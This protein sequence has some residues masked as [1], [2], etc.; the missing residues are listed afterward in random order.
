MAGWI[1][2]VSREEGST[3]AEVSRAEGSTTAEVSS[4]EGTTAEG[5]TPEVSRAEGTTAEASPAQSSPAQSSPA[6]S[7]PAQSIPAGAKPHPAHA[8][9]T[10]FDGRG[11]WTLTLR[12]RATEA[13]IATA[14]CAGIPAFATDL[15]KSPPWSNLADAIEGRRLLTQAE[16]QAHSQRLAI[17]N[18]DRKTTA[19]LLLERHIINATNG[20]R[21]HLLRAATVLPVRGYDGAARQVGATL[22]ASGLRP[23]PETTLLAAVRLA[24]RPAPGAR[25]GPAVELSREMTGRAA[26][27]AILDRLRYH[28]LSNEAG[29]REQLDTEFLHDFRV[30]A[31]RT[32]SLLRRAEGILDPAASSA[33]AS[34]LQWLGTLTG[35]VRDLDVHLEE[36]GPAG[37]DDLDPLRLY[38]QDRRDEA[39][40]ALVAALDSDRY[41][42]L[43]ERWRTIATIE[44]GLADAP[45][46]AR[47]AGEAAD[48]FI[49]RAFRRVLRRGQAI[50]DESPPEALHDLRKRAKELRYLL[51]CFQTLYP[52]GPRTTT[53]KELKA[54]QDNLGEFQDCQVQ[55]AAILETGERLLQARAAPAAT[56]MAMGRL[57]DE[58][59]QRELRARAE[60]AARFA[61]F[62][63]ADNTKRFAALTSG[64][65]KGG[66]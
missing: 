8:A 50:T 57:A 44:T 51:E 32:R 14:A 28:A 63:S 30:A 40:A 7:S 49:D 34:E 3:T 22:A 21:R 61:R 24:G 48:Y 55:A 53:V 12:D 65:E 1:L 25:L 42:N 29:T 47:G 46:A 23:A 38:M 20:D 54:L 18:D 33:L 27:A 52:H 56:L 62:S 31:R 41:R 17:L 66:R 36:L 11:T 13:V 58:Q 9:P 45:W 2:E 26:V 59:V 43:M 4:A 19:R 6:Q 60:F 5:T 39:Q 35:P 64:P 15:P 16:A 37:G 10:Q